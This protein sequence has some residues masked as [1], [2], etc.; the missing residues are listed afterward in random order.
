MIIIC[1]VL[2]FCSYVSMTVSLF[3]CI[4]FF[5]FKQKTAYEMRISDWS[6][7]VCSSDLPIPAAGSTQT[8]RRHE[9]REDRLSDRS[10]RPHFASAARRPSSCRRLSLCPLDRSM[11]RRRAA[12]DN[13]LPGTLHGLKAIAGPPRHT[14]DALRFHQLCQRFIIAP[15]GKN[16]LGR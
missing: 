4:F 14:L 16:E 6:S 2:V 13:G 9:L 8:T 12:D 11:S 3:I 7:D 15:H 10:Y 5:F 1:C